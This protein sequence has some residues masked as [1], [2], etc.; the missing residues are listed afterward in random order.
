MRREFVWGC[1]NLDEGEADQTV[2]RNG[3]AWHSAY[4]IISVFKM[5]TSSK[6]NKQR[7]K[8]IAVKKSDYW[9]RQ[10]LE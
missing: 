6:L 1:A 9:K 3:N 4:V 2:R 10:K 7:Y 8:S 5:N